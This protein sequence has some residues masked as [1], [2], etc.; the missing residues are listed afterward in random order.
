MKTLTAAHILFSLSLIAPTLAHGWLGTLTVASNK[1]K[2]HIGPAPVEQVGVLAPAASPIRQILNN[3]PIKDPRSADL[4]CGR[5]ASAAPAT[6]LARAEAGDVIELGWKTLAEG[7]RWFHDVGPMM[8]YLT[9]CGTEEGCKGVN[10]SEAEWFKIDEQ[11]VGA[12]GTWAQAKLDTGAPA[13]LTLPRTLAPGNYLLRF[14]IIALHTAQAPGG[15]EFYPACAQLSVS[16]AGTGKPTAGEL[17]RLPGAYKSTDRG[18]L[19]DVYDLPAGGYVFPGPRVAAFVT[20]GSVGAATSKTSSVKAASSKTTKAA[21]T[22][23]T[24]KGASSGK[25]TATHTSTHTS[26]SAPKSTA[27]PKTCKTSHA[28]RRRRALADAVDMEARAEAETQ[29]ADEGVEKQ[30][31]DTENDKKN[32]LSRARH[33]HRLGGPGRASF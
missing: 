23:K 5:G 27:S 1:A 17:V 2:A 15:A 11:G 13:T 24:S 30:V 3:L 19:V 12:D 20:G 32:Q 14:E 25:A 16:G 8:A 33:L 7:G 10:A 9:D 29:H 18:I 22:A 26:T 28:S 4:A 6:Q 31:K 21:A